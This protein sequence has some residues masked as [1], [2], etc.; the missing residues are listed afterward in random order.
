M[1]KNSKKILVIK[2]NY[3]W[4]QLNLIEIF[5]YLDLIRLLVQRDFVTF[6]KQT[7]L[8]PLW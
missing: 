7:I 6:Y 3:R 2:S 5:D 8:G 4:F 1:S